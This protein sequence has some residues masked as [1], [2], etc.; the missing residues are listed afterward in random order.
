MTEFGFVIHPVDAR[1]DVQ[2]KYPIA[3]Y[4]PVSLIEAM[5]ARKSPQIVS[6]INGVRSATGAETAGWFVGCPATPQMFMRM[7]VERAYDLIVEAVELVAA[8]GA[9]I[10]GLGAFTSVVGDA[11]KTVAKRSSV[12]VTTGNSYTVATAIQGAL[13]AAEIMEIDL[14]RARLAVVG[15]TGSIG[16]T[17]ALILAQKFDKTTVIGRDIGRLEAVMGELRGEGVDVEATTDV[18]QGLKDADVVMTVTS[19]AT[20]IIQPGHLKS[21][22]V[23]CDVAR[24]RDVARRVV[25]ERQDVLVVEGGVVQVPGNVDFGFD[26]GFPEGMAFAC[27]CETMILALENRPESFTVGKDVSVEQ[28]REIAALAEKH[29]FQVAGFRS[30]ERAVT[31]T[32]IQAIVR[33]VR[34]LRAV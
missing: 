6:H 9:K 15:A 10:V 20:S 34:R 23:V 22:A 5:L 12:A 31:D 26:F 19:A 13:R 18:S 27:M 3:K 14:G 28:V 30:F 2:R 21:G 32:D 8:K 29:G 16:R 25:E 4:L 24:P 17:C 7:P 11:G 1:R 33:N